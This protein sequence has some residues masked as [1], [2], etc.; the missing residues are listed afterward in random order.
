M[1]KAQTQTRPA[2]SNAEQRRQEA[3]AGARQELVTR[4]EGAVVTQEQVPDYIK[5]GQARGNENVEMT[6]VVI[7]RIELVQA[8]SK[9]LKENDPSY[10]EGIKQGELYNTVTRE[11][12]GPAISVVPVLFTKQWLAWRDQEKGGGFA[13]AHPTAEACEKAIEEQEDP[14]DWEATET[15]QQL[16]LVVKKDGSIEEAVVSMNKT[17]LKVSR[18][19]NALIRLNGNDRFS[20]IYVLHSVDE[21]NSRNQDFKNYGVYAMGFPP[22][23]V[24]KHAEKLYL[25]VR[26]GA[27]KMNVDISDH[28]SEDPAPRGTGEF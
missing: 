4:E 23:E 5:R 16:V 6:D 9:C 3:Q 1:A 26:S 2:A 10:I 18:N 15:A 17:K 19:W 22:L 11:N 8:L 28:E 14:D 7:P 25:S 21:T 27:R 20:R 12:Y 24:Y 13:G